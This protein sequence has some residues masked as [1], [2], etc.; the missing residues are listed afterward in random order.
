MVPNTNKNSERK[1][2]GKKD[3]EKSIEACL[4]SPWMSLS[5]TW[6]GGNRTSNPADGSVLH[7]N[8]VLL[9]KKFQEAA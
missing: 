8:F 3:E 6:N 2:K 1:M 5:G 9:C 4:D 7:G